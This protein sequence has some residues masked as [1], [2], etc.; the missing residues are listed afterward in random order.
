MTEFE[1]QMGI[2][3]LKSVYGEKAYPKERTEIIFTKV[4]LIKSAQWNHVVATLIA[5]A[6]YA[7]ML[8][9]ILKAARGFI[10]EANKGEEARRR[11]ILEQRKAEGKTC[12]HCDDSGLISAYKRETS[13]SFSFRC[14]DEQCIAAQLNCNKHDVRWSE[15]YAATYL[16]VFASDKHTD[17]FERASPNFIKERDERIAANPKNRMHMA[18]VDCV[19]DQIRSGTAGDVLDQQ[20][21]AHIETV[22]RFEDHGALTMPDTQPNEPES[23]Q[24]DEAP[25]F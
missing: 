5:S 1:F 23:L 7:P 15:D 11:L 3:R 2:D 6:R 14:P 10:E 20:R 12:R 8:E 19:L 18:L 9:D 4:Y 22:K 13:Y 25:P 24:L 17:H 16:P 21:T